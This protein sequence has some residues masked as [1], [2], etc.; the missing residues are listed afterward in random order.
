MNLICHENNVVTQFVELLGIF[1]G[2][3]CVI[4]IA[5][6][7]V[8]QLR[9]RQIKTFS[10][11]GQL[12]HIPH[13]IH[14][15]ILKPKIQKVQVDT[16]DENPDTFDIREF[17]KAREAK[18]QEQHN[19]NDQ[20]SP[21][22]LFESGLGHHCLNWS[23]V[24]PKIAQTAL[25]VAYDRAG[26]GWSG[27]SSFPRTSDQIAQE[28]HR[29]LELAQI[30]GPYLLVGHSSG[31][32]Y[33][34]SFLKLYPGE[35]S[36][37]VLIDAMHPKEC[38][39]GFLRQKVLYRSATILSYFGVNCFLKRRLDKTSNQFSKM[40]EALSYQKKTTA[41]AYREYC[42]YPSSF[43]Q[44]QNIK[45]AKNIP[46]IVLT[47]VEGNKNPKWIALQKDFLNI[48][49][50]SEQILCKTGHYIQIEKPDLVADVI[51][52]LIEKIRTKSN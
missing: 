9:E 38:L 52:K 23:F 42:Q 17:S 27:Q 41:T 5:G 46:I 33:V 34:R 25:T 32:L 19:P 8:Q 48:S 28:F 31:G 49:E 44:V 18:L 36:G 14:L 6:R 26:M 3:S 10:P 35:V 45:S 24:Q 16:D 4:L 40:N 12:V 20:L 51:L 30:S 47:H 43:I 1:L 50:D 29:A 39:P 13:F 2:L 37:L 15:R 21:T 11:P 7:G 22:V